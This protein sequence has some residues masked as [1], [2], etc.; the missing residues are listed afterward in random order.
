MELVVVGGSNAI[1]RGVIKAMAP[2]C[3]KI[4]LV[5]HRPFRKSVYAMQRT[6]PAS[7]EIEKVQVQ[8]GKAVEYALE[9]ADSVLYFTHDYLAMTHDKND[10]LKRAAISCSK[11][12]AGN[13]VAVCPVELDMHYTEDKQSSVEKRNEAEH[14]ALAAFENTALLR[15]NIVFGDD[16]HFV[17][18]LTQ[19][20]FAGRVPKTIGGANSFS[21]NP[22]HTDDLTACITTAIEKMSEAKGQRWSVCGAD[23]VTVADIMAA[24][25]KAAGTAPAK[26]TTVM[27]L[28]DFVEEWFAGIA[29]D[30]NLGKMV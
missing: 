28:T 30:K 7:C 12:G 1:A 15:P 29:H 4:K 27:G 6:V 14:E 23:S 25:D 21:F 18:Y 26:H 24:C 20:A 11:V 3:S 8:S 16:T 5:D 10:Y 9:G 17:H 22:V 19:C 2:S 13:L